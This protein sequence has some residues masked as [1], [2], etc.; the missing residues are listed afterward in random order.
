MYVRGYR[1]NVSSGRTSQAALSAVY[2]SGCQ[3]Y[4]L[5]LTVCRLQTCWQI[6]DD[7]ITVSIPPTYPE[8]WPLPAGRDVNRCPTCCSTGLPSPKG[9]A[10]P[11]SSDLQ[12]GP[13]NLSIHPTSHKHLLIFSKQNYSVS[14]ENWKEDNQQVWHVV[15]IPVIGV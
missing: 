15:T 12:Y 14:T 13:D 10:S 8:G 7:Q 1:V 3:T 9:H 11:R 4:K 6:S 2:L 5:V